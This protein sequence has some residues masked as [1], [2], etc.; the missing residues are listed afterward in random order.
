M[1]QIKHNTTLITFTQFYDCTLYL[2]RPLF[3]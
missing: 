2:V 3:G 1:D